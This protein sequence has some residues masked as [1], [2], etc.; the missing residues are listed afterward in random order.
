[1][2]WLLAAV[3]LLIVSSIAL[4]LLVPPTSFGPNLGSIPLAQ[5]IGWLRWIVLGALI[6]PLSEVARV[7][8]LTTPLHEVA[9]GALVLDLGKK[10]GIAL[11]LFWLL[12][13]AVDVDIAGVA[14]QLERS[15]VLAAGVAFILGFYGHVTKKLLKIAIIDG[16]PKYLERV[17]RRPLNRAT[18]DEAYVQSHVH[19]KL[20]RAYL[21][22]AS[23]D[24]GRDGH[25][26][27]RDVR[28]GYRLAGFLSKAGFTV[29]AI[30]TVFLA[31]D[32]DLTADCNL[33]S[34]IAHE[35][36]HIRQRYWSDS[37]RQE[38]DAYRVGA[39]V[40]RELQDRG[41]KR[42]SGTS[43]WLTL[44]DEQAKDKVLSLKD[45]APLYGMIPPD[46]KTE[47]AAD[48]LEFIR[49]AIRLGK[50]RLGEAIE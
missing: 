49:Q 20:Q 5:W 31:D 22:A 35:A 44:D 26:T 38:A 48:K 47:W 34:L 4:P 8:R 21:L 6:A 27:S 2:W 1:V 7:I 25:I 14:L 45:R 17:L 39:R 11:A 23:T 50:W 10:A 29:N 15:P 46:Q 24:A 33:A 30:N 43:D 32:L 16:V 40:M 9:L 41:V 12:V 19:P 18:D 37:L 3:L 28:A 42:C 36:S 13:K